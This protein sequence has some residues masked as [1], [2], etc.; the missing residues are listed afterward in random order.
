MFLALIFSLIAA[1]AANLQE[2]DSAQFRLPLEIPANFS[3]NYGELRSNHFHSGLDF[4]TGG[5]IGLKVIAPADGYISRV[6]ISP[7]GYGRALYITHY[8]GYTT[9]YGHLDGF[10][11]ELNSIILSKQYEMEESN[12]DFTMDESVMPVKA[13]EVV[14][15][16]GNTGSSGGPHLHYEIRNTLSETPLDALARGFVRTTDTRKPE[17]RR[18][19]IIGCDSIG[20]V[21]QL[22]GFKYAGEVTKVPQRFIVAVDAVDR[23]EGTPA[24]LAVK[25]YTYYIDSTKFFYLNIGE[26]PFEKGRYIN[27]LIYYPH[28][29]QG[30]AAMIQSLVEE[31]NMLRDRIVALNNGIVE[32]KDTCTH[33]LR[34]EVADY[35]GNISTRSYRIRA[36]AASGATAASGAAASSGAAAAENDS[37][38]LYANWALATIWKGPGLEV[39]IPPAAL[40][41]SILFD[42]Q[43]VQ[44]SGSSQF[45]KWRIGN[46][47]VPL[48]IA[49][50]INMDCSLPDSLITK[51]FVARVDRGKEYIGGKFKACAQDSAGITNGVYTAKVRSFGTYTILTDTTPPNVKPSLKKGLAVLNGSLRFTIWDNLSGIGRYTVKIDGEW[52]PAFFDAKIRR[53]TVKLSDGNIGKG[54]HKIEV[55]VCDNCGN[56]GRYSGT[57]V[58]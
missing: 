15:Y 38:L 46:K 29:A 56:V 19:A 53:L 34:I 35:A 57:F 8:N 1:T 50:T 20:G 45:P 24:A 31:G 25:E 5:A 27:S 26:V 12:L 49:V 48:H 41:R 33:R 37:T 18:T 4:R 39:I 17:I 9:V 28:R 14:A 13:G 11:K 47:K 44:E 6:S 30:G 2:S 22:S 43:R 3:G 10:S 16:T 42:A 54:R 52:I 21:L 55:E 58:K 51:S 40:Y 7:Y 23:Q 32:L 36:A